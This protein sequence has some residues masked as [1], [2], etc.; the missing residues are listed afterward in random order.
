[1]ALRLV[2]IFLPAQAE[3]K[4]FDMI[5]SF[6]SAVIVQKEYADNQL[7]TQLLMKAERTELLLDKLEAGFLNK[8]E[9][10]IIIQSVEATIPRMPQSE[11]ED[12]S[13]PKTT[14]H[15]IKYARLSREELYTD[16]QEASQLTWLFIIMVVFS[17]IVAA[18]G[19]LRNN[20]AVV[21]GA[22]VIAPLLGPNVALALASALGDKDLGRSARR[23]NI[24]GIAI[25]IL[26]AVLVGL[27]IKWDSTYTE[28]FSR[29]EI[30]LSDIILALVA[31]AVATMSFTMSMP[32]TIIGVMVAV[33]LLPPL[34]SSGI[35]LGSGQFKLAFEAGLLFLTNLICVNLAG[36]LT[37]LIQGI[38]PI[39]WWEKEKAR[40]ATRRA[41]ITWII[42]LGLLAL[43]I[44]A[45]QL[46]W[47]DKLA[48]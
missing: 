17:S 48:E 45:S 25:P 27:C 10:R 35:L 5:D 18:I 38:Q 33:A 13:E 3:A 26:I 8:D 44:L 15:K 23:A 34:V 4:L 21:I 42:C 16:I 37:F 19:L 6:P 40:R 1:M 31:G 36:V 32:S 43:S 14:K 47:L 7:H 20:T 29:T 11:P 24:A 9:F 41:L 22:M 12:A 2:E 28:I 46:G 30:N 39:W